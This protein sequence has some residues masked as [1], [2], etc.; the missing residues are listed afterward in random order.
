MLL[1]LSSSESVFSGSS[2]PS[3]LSGGSSV[4]PFCF[5]GSGG[6]DPSGGSSSSGSSG[7]SGF[8]FGAEGPVGGS[9]LVGASGAVGA[10]GSLGSGSVA[11]FGA[12]TAGACGA[13][14]TRAAMG[15]PRLREISCL[16]LERDSIAAAFARC[17]RRLAATGS[18]VSAEMPIDEP[19]NRIAVAK[20]QEIYIRIKLTWLWIV[21]EIFE[22]G[23][24][25]KQ[26]EMNLLFRLLEGKVIE[27]EFI[28]STT[29]I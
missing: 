24:T 20:G 26:A 1:L 23:N 18:R 2:L 4:S 15:L 16:L 5:G 7:S 19:K 25:E 14:G 8:C 11:G 29:E 17:E 3:G 10:S 22:D 13:L 6:S 12:L 27:A 21:F 28:Y 9:G